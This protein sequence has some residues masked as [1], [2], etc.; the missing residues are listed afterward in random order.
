MARGF[1]C[2]HTA[3]LRGDRLTPLAPL[4]AALLAAQAGP[5]DYL[6]VS[7]PGEVVA[8]VVEA[9]GGEEAIRRNGAMVQEGEVT[10]V[11]GGQDPVRLTRIFERPGRL[12][13]TVSYPGSQGQEQRVVDGPRAWRDGEEVS[14]TPSHRAMELQAARLDLPF[15]LLEGRDRVVDGGEVVADGRRL[16]VLTL[17]LGAETSLTVEIDVETARVVRS[18]TRLRSP[19]VNLEFV[20]VYL[21]HRKVSGV[22]VPFREVN[23]AQGRRTGTTVL[24]RVEFLRE[25]PTGAFRP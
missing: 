5:P 6:L 2:W 11:L 23:Q 15:L 1:A 12:R 14:G 17:P 10:S 20:T 16:H 25:A 22:L 13:V 21:D 7:G 8:R 24:Q 3:R 9:Y 19:R 18:I 4:V